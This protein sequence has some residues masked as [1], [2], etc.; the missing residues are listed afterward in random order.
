[1]LVGE[2]TIKFPPVCKEHTSLE[3]LYGLLDGSPDRL[4]VVIDGDAHRVPIGVITERSICE[5]MILR[6]RDPRDL[7]AANVLDCEITKVEAGRDIRDVPRAFG[8]R[9]PVIVIDSDHRYL[10]IADTASIALTGDLSSP[11]FPPADP[12][13]VNGGHPI[14]GLA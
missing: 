10:G 6:K 9:K 11:D 5:Q 2:L 8:T 3:Q 4:V 12:V 7:T 1:M 14:L 13:T